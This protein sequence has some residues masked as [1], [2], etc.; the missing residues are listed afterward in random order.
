MP[1][2]L[3]WH[4]GFGRMVLLKLGALEKN[5][6][7]E[8]VVTLICQ[9]PRL[10]GELLTTVKHHD[11]SQQIQTQ[12]AVWMPQILERFCLTTVPLSKSHLCRP[13]T[14]RQAPS[15]DDATHWVISFELGF[16]NSL[17]AMHGSFLLCGLLQQPLLQ[18]FH[19]QQIS[20]K[21]SFVLQL[22]C[23]NQL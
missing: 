11:S 6:E 10:H 13:L 4:I 8:W 20:F 1:M 16:K 9:I 5:R 22:T 21:D 3:E 7:T 14:V 2:V 23:L 12:T 15:L 17:A 18:L 19:L